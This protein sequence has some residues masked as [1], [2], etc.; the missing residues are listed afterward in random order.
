M[1]DLYDIY[2]TS[3]ITI[4][5][6]IVFIFVLVLIVFMLFLFSKG[7]NISLPVELPKG[8]DYEKKYTISPF[9][10]YYVLNTASHGSV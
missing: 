7:S 9:V 10:N 8:I 3:E 5:I 4:I 1:F 2:D 6:L